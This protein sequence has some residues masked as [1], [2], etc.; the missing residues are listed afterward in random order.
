MTR[1]GAYAD[2]LGDYLIARHAPERNEQ[3]ARV[4]PDLPDGGAGSQQQAAS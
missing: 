4:N 3:I 2:E 1:I